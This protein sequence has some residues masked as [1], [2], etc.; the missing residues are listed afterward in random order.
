MRAV[1]TL[2]VIATLDTFTLAWRP[3]DLNHS[4][5][6]FF[7]GDGCQIGHSNPVFNEKYADT[8]TQDTQS[9]SEKL[10]EA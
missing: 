5:L 1:S 8:L 4:Y 2:S 9:A 3:M 7:L 10:F 6:P